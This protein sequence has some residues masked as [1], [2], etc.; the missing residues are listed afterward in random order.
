MTANAYLPGVDVVLNDLGL[1]VAPPPSGPK[2]T[3]LGITSNP[4]VPIREPFTVSS[5]EKAMHTLYFTTGTDTSGVFPGEL[6]LAMEQAVNGGATN[7]EVIVIG[8]YT[9][10]QLLSYVAPTGDKSQRYADLSGAYDVLRHRDLDVV[11][12]VGVYADYTGSQNFAK[13]LAD[14]C[15]QATQESN[16]CR[17][18]IGVAPVLDWAWMNSAQLQ[19][20]VTGGASGTLMSEITG[21]FG[22]SDSRYNA[23]FGTPSAELVNEYV[24]YHSLA[25]SGQFKSH[26]HD[27]ANYNTSYWNWLHGAF[28]SDGTLHSTT[29]SDVY[30]SYWTSWQAYD[31]DGAAAVDGRGIK[32]DAGAYITILNAPVRTSGTQ[33][34]QMQTSFSVAPTSQYINV[35]GAAAYAG[36]R[37]SLAPQSA[38]TNKP[39][40]GLLPQRLLSASQANTLSGMRFATMYQRSK[41]FVVAAGNT[42]AYNVSDY[43]RSDYV[44]ETT[45]SIAQAVVD[46]IRAVGE[47]YLGE[48]NT[49]ARMNALDAEIRQVL[50]SMTNQGAL[51]GSDFVISSTPDQRVLGI[52]DITLTIV[53]AFEIRDINLTVS[54]AKEL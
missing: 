39:V 17:G 50:Q 40:Y 34:R 19:L 44:N 27:S 42:G 43:V 20:N 33:V 31:S 25:A 32:V 29:A 14:F 9:G 13:Q 10:S 49:A 36:L 26:V 47:K 51:N 52:L 16:S 11:V 21:F 28:G 12:P 37:T 1:K 46:L 4:D 15:F 6:A 3:L 8:T 38:T 35:C 23:L 45:M 5:V 24:R 22:G 7:I 41:G 54:M 53:P 2:V 30:A 48:P 18:V